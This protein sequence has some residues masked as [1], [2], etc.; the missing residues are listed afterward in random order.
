MKALPTHTLTKPSRI[1]PVAVIDVTPKALPTQ[2]EIQSDTNHISP[3]AWLLITLG[4]V[5][6]FLFIG[7]SVFPKCFYAPH[8][9]CQFMNRIK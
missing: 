4:S 1:I 2:P 3:F 9:S 7:F 5:Y 8:S 6:M